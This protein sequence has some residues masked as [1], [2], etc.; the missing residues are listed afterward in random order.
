MLS[1]KYSF[2]G[3]GSWEWSYSLTS[4][5]LPCMYVIE[6]TGIHWRSEVCVYV[7]WP[8]AVQKCRSIL[9]LCPNKW[10][11]KFFFSIDLI[12]YFLLVLFFLSFYMLFFST[13]ILFLSTRRTS[14]AFILLLLSLIV[15]TP[16]L[17]VKTAFFLSVTVSQK[18]L[19]TTTSLHLTWPDFLLSFPRLVSMRS[20]N[21]K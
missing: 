7:C 21:F 5:L 12:V 6:C 10:F 2:E 1:L 3:Y 19:F 15:F 9:S 17:C 20:F 18:W 14:F 4:Q 11:Q 16:L 8:T 13:C